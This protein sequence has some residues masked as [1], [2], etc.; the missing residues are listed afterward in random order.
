MGALAMNQAPENHAGS[1][2]QCAVMAAVTLAIAGAVY[3]GTIA[4]VGFPDGHLTDY[5]EWALP[6]RKV[7]VGAL[8]F[9]GAV[10]VALMVGKPRPSAASRLFW[11]GVVMVIIAT[12]AAVALIPAI[13]LSWLRLD[14]GQGG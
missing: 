4:G 11:I 13:G 6:L 8:G 5:Q 3:V 1:A 2:V 9:Y 12:L 7:A 14:D 10:F